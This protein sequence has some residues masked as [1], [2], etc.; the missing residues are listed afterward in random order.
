[1]GNYATHRIQASE[2]M[3]Y[4]HI[5]TCLPIEEHAQSIFS[6]FAFRS[7]QHELV[8]AMQYASSE[9]ADGSYVLRHFKKMDGERL[10]I[11]IPEAEQIHC[12][13]KEFESSGILCRHALRVLLIKNY[14]E[15]PEKYLPS[16]WRQESLSAPYDNQGDQ[17][18]SDEWFQ[19]FR[20]LTGTLFTESSITKERSDFVHRELSKEIK[21]LINEVTNMPPSDG[22]TMDLTFSPTG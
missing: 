8:Q 4:M 5:R 7:F 16:R 2:E 19:E 22:V 13:C 20:S 10:V 6:P 1:M 12:S 21:R 15:L 17:N 11:W 18:A 3:Q 14:F 9:M